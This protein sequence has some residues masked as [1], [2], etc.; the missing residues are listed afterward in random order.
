MI[1]KSLGNFKDS[2]EMAEKCKRDLPN[3]NILYQNTNYNSSS[4]AELTINNP[5]EK[6]TYIKLYTLKNELVARIFIR[7]YQKA[8]I[9]LPGGTYHLNRAYGDDW[10]DEK[11]L[12]GDKGSYLKYMVKGNYDFTL[13][14]RDK[15]ILDQ[16]GNDSTTSVDFGSF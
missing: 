13:N 8:S 9:K 10:Y 14:R 16:E 12:F 11:D 2:K 3:R 1:Y 5:G 4:A 7:K 6:N 15:L